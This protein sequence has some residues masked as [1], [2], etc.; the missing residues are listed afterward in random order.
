[1]DGGDPLDYNTMVDQD[2]YRKQYGLFSEEFLQAS[3]NNTIVRGVPSLQNTVD[4]Y[5]ETAQKAAGEAVVGLIP[6]KGL[7][8]SKGVRGFIMKYSDDV[9]GHTKAMYQGKGS[10]E[11]LPAGTKLYRYSQKEA[12][13]KHYFTLDKN[14][15][16]H[17][18]GKNP[19]KMDP[20]N[21][22]FEE[23][24]LEKPVEVLKSKVNLIDEPGATQVFSP[25]IQKSS[26]SKVLK[27]YG[28][29]N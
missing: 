24:T 21:T 8:A 25:E 20:E 13:D 27:D 11:T 28:N 3:A 5:T 22:I 4:L 15:L 9:A 17:Q 23:F 6:I 16:P 14:A 1:M 2:Y 12:T 18:V 29:G 10:V 7:K 26:T 19:N